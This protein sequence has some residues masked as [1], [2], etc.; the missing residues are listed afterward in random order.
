[1]LYSHYLSQEYWFL[2]VY[3]A[4]WGVE[5]FFVLSGFLITQLLLRAGAKRQFRAISLSSIFKFYGS[6]FLRLAPALYFGLAIGYLAGSAGVATS[7]W[8]HALYL[9]N[10]FLFSPETGMALA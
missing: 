1:M 6:R 4:R 8:W 5:L 2:G 7:W 3:W 9:S 10:F